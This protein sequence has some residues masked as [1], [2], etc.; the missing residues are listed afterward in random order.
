MFGPKDTFQWCDQFKNSPIIQFRRKLTWVSVMISVLG[1]FCSLWL[2]STYYTD[3]FAGRD[4]RFG[5]FLVHGYLPDSPAFIPPC[6]PVACLA[7]S[8][9]LLAFMMHLDCWRTFKHPFLASIKC[10]AIEITAKGYTELDYESMISR[11]A[12]DDAN[13]TSQIRLLHW[14]RRKFDSQTEIR[15]T[16]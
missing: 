12:V 7:V 9:L 14:T 16:S 6:L 5:D 13:K 4:R 3:V 15:H 11:N 1:Q 8:V 10:Q 2:M